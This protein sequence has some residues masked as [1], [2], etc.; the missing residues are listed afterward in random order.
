MHEVEMIQ[1]VL[2]IAVARAKVE[3]IPGG[4]ND[5][6]LPG[7]LDT[8]DVNRNYKWRDPRSDLWKNAQ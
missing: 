3:D 6:T 7:G 5:S 2:E 1:R 4:T 8:N